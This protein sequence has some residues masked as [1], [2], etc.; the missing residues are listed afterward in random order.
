MPIYSYRCASCG[1]AKDVLQRVSDPVL[2]A[3]PA[4]GA[5]TFM[6]QLTAAGFQLKG[7]GWYVTDFKGDAKP[8][9]APADPGKADP[10]KA[11][12]AG[13]E[14]GAPA[15]APKTGAPA[16]VPKTNAADTSA[17]AAGSD[18]AAAGASAAGTAPSGR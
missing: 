16:D 3:C 13:G 6:K 12:P 18:K 5:E 9:K 7:S 1:H 17:A 11:D 10:A 14:A 15:D 8:A 4:C 2:S